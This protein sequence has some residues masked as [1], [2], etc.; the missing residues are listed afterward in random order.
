MR[1]TILVLLLSLGL[2]AGC[3]VNPVTGERQLVLMSTTQEIELGRQ[4]YAPMQQ[5]QGGQYDVDPE[6]TAYVRGVGNKVAA[7]SG[8]EARYQEWCLRE[9]LRRAHSTEVLAVRRREPACR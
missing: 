9:V 6:L 1:K 5:A 8:V 3:S 7:Q 2:M 4:N